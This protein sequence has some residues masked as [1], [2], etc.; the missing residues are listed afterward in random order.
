MVG[1]RPPESQEPVVDPESPT[2]WDEASLAFARGR[3]TEALWR[4]L[5]A[6]LLP[7]VRGKLLEQPH[8]VE[9]VISDTFVNLIELRARGQYDPARG[10]VVALART[11]AGRRCTDRLRRRYHHQASSLE[12]MAD[13][14]PD[15]RVGPREVADPALGTEERVILGDL[16]RARRAA[17]R[18]ALVELQ[19]DDRRIGSRRALA[20]LLRYRYAIEDDDFSF[21]FDPRRASP[22]LAPWR[23]IAERLGQTE[24]AARQS[25]SRGLRALRDLLERTSSAVF[26]P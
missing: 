13:P 14:E 23:E 1:G 24:E 7:Q 5:R 26:A 6:V 16:V 19:Q 21:V 2:G 8:E 11:I 10:T 12:A 20:V 9:D 3:E 18:D 17:F 22:G 25:G 4:Q 15:G